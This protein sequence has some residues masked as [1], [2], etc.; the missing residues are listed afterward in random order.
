M[1]DCDAVEIGRNRPLALGLAGHIG[2][3]LRQL[4]EALPPGRRRAAR[5]G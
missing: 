5:S 3:V 4:T 1:V 2:L